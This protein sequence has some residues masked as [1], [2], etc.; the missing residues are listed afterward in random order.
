MSQHAELV[1]RYQDLRKVALRL[2]NR[3]AESLS[4]SI[5]DEGGKKLGILRG[6]TLVLDTED[7]IAV[8]MDY[9][10]YDVRRKGLNAVERYLAESPPPADSD[11]MILHQAMRH[12]RYSL[13]AVEALEP[14]VGVQ[15]HDLLL[16]EP[17]FLM[18]IGFSR[19]APL[20]M[21]LAAR[22]YAPEGILQTTGAALPVGVLPAAGRAKLLQ[23]V[24]KQ[25]QEA[26]LRNLS[27]EQASELSATV[28][29]TCL[30]QGA[31]EHIAY[32]GPKTAGGGRSLSATPPPAQRSA[33]NRP[34]SCGSGKKF[35]NCC[36]ARR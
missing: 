9:C 32:V 5:L 3:L 15:V 21:V 31:A 36:G 25:F 2:N 33:R 24:L 17:L 1:P 35:K 27:P 18:D 13:F 30:R 20:G 26:D 4:R 34:C 10:I 12:A 16:K 22:V 6:N 23:G 8:L 29:R 28:I 7:E 19:T 14:R 11:E